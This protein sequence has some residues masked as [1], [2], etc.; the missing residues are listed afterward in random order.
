MSI[1]W[2]AGSAR[3]CRSCASGLTPG[4]RRIRSCRAPPGPA[5]GS[6]CRAD[7]GSAARLFLFHDPD[8]VPFLGRRVLAVVAAA[9]D[10]DPRR[11]I[12]WRQLE[13]IAEATQRAGP[14]ALLV[15]IETGFVGG[16][17]RRQLREALRRV[18]TQ[19]FVYRGRP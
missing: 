10:K 5:A 15:G 1:W 14:V 2:R 17:H 3:F 4:P 8:A 16:D 11:P 18:V 9:V 13:R 19:G 7:A 6:R 12:V